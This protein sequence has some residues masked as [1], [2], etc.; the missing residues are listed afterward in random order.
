MIA[1]NLQILEEKISEICRNNGRSRSDLTLIGIS[2]MNP[3]SAILDAFKAGVIHFGENKAQEF[4]NKAPDVTENVVWH[5]VGHLQTNKVKY[6][7][8]YADY[9]HSVDSVKLVHEIDKRAGKIDRIPKVLLELNTSGEES[10]FGLS[11]DD[12]ILEVAESCKN[13]GNLELVGLMTMAPY[14]EDTEIVRKTFR[15]LRDKK[16]WLNK[17]GYGLTELSMG[18]TND[19]D[20]AI[21]EGATMLR[22]GTAIFGERDY[23]KNGDE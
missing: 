8:K 13:S 14:T 9:I 23:S 12:E 21:E 2:K 11:R 15:G 10:K 6:V 7:I 16:D 3:V 22:I 5:F 17:K 19:Y 18:M 1:E 20:I 4:Q